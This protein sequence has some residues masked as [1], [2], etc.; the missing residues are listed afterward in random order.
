MTTFTVSI[1]PAA[2]GKFGEVNLKFGYDFEGVI[3]GNAAFKT[4]PGYL[5]ESPIHTGEI[6]DFE[7]TETQLV[8]AGFS[9]GAEY[10]FAIPFGDSGKILYPSFLKIGAGVQYLFP[11]ASYPQKL[12][13]KER[14]A[15]FFQSM[16]SFS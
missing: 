8:D 10:L 2:D 1:V 9:L 14:P 13:T 11:V 7:Q 16:Q 3:K 4:D 12:W 6:E 15:R 5:Q